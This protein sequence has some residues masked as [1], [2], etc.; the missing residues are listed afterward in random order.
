MES[1]LYNIYSLIEAYFSICV[2]NF[3]IKIVNPHFPWGNLYIFMCC[4]SFC[5]SQFK[6]W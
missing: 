4:D 2:L 1:A 6:E 3:W 5:I